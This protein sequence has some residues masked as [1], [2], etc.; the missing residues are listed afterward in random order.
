MATFSPDEEQKSEPVG[1]ETTPV[2]VGVIVSQEPDEGLVE[3][4]NTNTV[5][6]SI[7]DMLL[8]LRN[9]GTCPQA[10]KTGSHP[11]IDAD[12]FDSDV[13][14]RPEKI[15]S[16]I[17]SCEIVFSNLKKLLSDPLINSQLDASEKASIKLVLN[18]P[19]FE[20]LVESMYDLAQSKCTR[21]VHDYVLHGKTTEGDTGLTTA[22][23]TKLENIITDLQQAGHVSR[24]IDGVNSLIRFRNDMFSAFN[25]INITTNRLLVEK[26]KVDP[27]NKQDQKT[28]EKGS[29]KEANVGINKESAFKKSLR[30]LGSVTKHAAYAVAVYGGLFVISPILPSIVADG[31]LGV[32]LIGLGVKAVS[33]IVKIAK[34]KK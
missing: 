31:L 33:D 1:G 21:G 3:A 29:K 2:D 27:T 30:I 20:K 24:D 13:E 26:A 15:A 25:L 28:S 34:G 11:G 23:A 12:F 32:G 14:G 5:P 18:A 16:L 6:E 22:F 9:V 10:F 19:T 8:L 4:A 7:S 17:G